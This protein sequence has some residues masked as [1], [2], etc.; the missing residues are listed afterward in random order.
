M[1]KY[2]KHDLSLDLAGGTDT[3]VGTSGNDAIFLQNLVTTGDVN[4]LAEIGESIDSVFEGERLIG[5]NN[6]DLGNGDNLLD[7]SGNSTSLLGESLNITVGSGQ[8]ILW[9]SDGN[10]NIATGEGNDEIIVN[11]GNDILI[12]GND[13][14]KITIA[15]NIG[16]LTISDF[17][18]NKDELYFETSI[19][20][21]SASGNTITVS[22]N[23]GDY[24][25]TLTGNDTVDLT[26]S[27]FN[28][29]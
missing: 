7:L 25:I 6:I 17:D 16:N 8:D 2:L 19:S 20:N 13:S 28:F 22:N 26:G 21:V 5:L 4:W 10:E 23:I 3:L 14:D 18:A 1:S 15:N 27:A 12:T 29:L 11:G 9:L 24:I